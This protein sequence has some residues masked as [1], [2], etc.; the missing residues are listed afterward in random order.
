MSNEQDKPAQEEDFA[1]LFA[2]QQTGPA[3]RDGQVVKGRVM[4]IDAHSVFVDVQGDLFL[5]VSSQVSPQLLV[6]YT[7][8]LPGFARPYSPTYTPI[9]NA[10]ER[11]VEAEYR[12]NRFFYITTGFAQRRSLSTSLSPGPDTPEFDVNLKARWEY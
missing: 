11:N 4:Q 7:Q 12:L 9:E 1:A 5:K 2:H 6:S 10:F 8:K 3:L